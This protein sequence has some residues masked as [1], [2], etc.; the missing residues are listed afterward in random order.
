MCTLKYSS[1]DSLRWRPVFGRSLR[2]R[3]KPGLQREKLFGK[4]VVAIRVGRGRRARGVSWAPRIAPEGL[5]PRRGGDTIAQAEGL[6]CQQIASKAPQGRGNGVR[7]L[8]RPVRAFRFVRSVT[9]AFGLGYRRVGPTGL[10][11]SA[12]VKRREMDA[13]DSCSSEGVNQEWGCESDLRR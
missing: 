7:A 12:T 9:Q 3:L 2:G 4:L 8:R 5:Q 10:R 1:A 13:V 6:G 11:E